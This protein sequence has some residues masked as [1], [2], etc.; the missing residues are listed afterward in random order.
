MRIFFYLMLGLCGLGC[1]GTPSGTTPLTSQ[2]VITVE[3]PITVR[4]NTPFTALLLETDQRNL[5]VL[6]IGE[7]QRQALQPTLPA[8]FRITGTVYADHWNGKTYTHLRPIA[9]ERL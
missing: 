4:G 5:Y 3:G 2:E 6:V 7:A 1:A 8:H 9:M